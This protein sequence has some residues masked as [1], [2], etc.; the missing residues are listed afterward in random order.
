MLLN[1]GG[2]RTFLALPLGGGCAVSRSALAAAAAACDAAFASQGLPPLRPDG[3]CNAYEPHASVA[4]A[5]GDARAPLAEE[6]AR[7][8]VGALGAVRWAAPLR[9]VTLRVGQKEASCWGE[10]EALDGAL[11]F[12]LHT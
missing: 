2:T 6:A 8:G 10:G 7:L 9:R 1:D 5:L 4:W 11:R 12:R 3:S